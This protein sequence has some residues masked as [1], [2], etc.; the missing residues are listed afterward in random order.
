MLSST[1]TPVLLGLLPF[2]CAAPIKTTGSTDPTQV[3]SVDFADPDL[4]QDGTQWWAFASNNHKTIAA[5]G[6]NLINVQIARSPDFTTWTVTGGDA[7]PTVGAWVDPKAGNQGAAVWAPSVSKNKQGQYVMT[8]SAAV[9]GKPGKHCLGAAVASQP[10]GP[11]T[12]QATPLACP[13]SEGGA[14]DSDNFMDIDGTQYV[15]YKI[16]GNSVGHGGVCNNGNAPIVD[17]PIMLQKV[18]DDGFTPVGTPVKLLDRSELDGPLVEAPSLMRTANGKYVLF[19]SSNCFATSNYDV[20]Y[21]FADSINGP[22]VKRGPMMVT[23]TDGLFAPGGQAIA[24]DGKHMMFHA[25]NVGPANMGWRGAY[26]Q[27]I[28]VD[29]TRQVVWA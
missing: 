28:N 26:T 9:K 13:L 2:A 24:A 17:T 20:T 5:V 16:D 29:T 19:F 8:Y 14:I 3:I 7:L 21:A 27:I 25:G 22:Y 10:Q 18:A 6:G 15:L 1:I 12:P 4:L 11:Y 23:G